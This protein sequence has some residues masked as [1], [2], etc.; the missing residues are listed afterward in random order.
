MWLDAVDPI[1][2]VASLSSAERLALPLI[3]AALSPL[4]LGCP[5]ALGA[6]RAIY[7]RDAEWMKHQPEHTRTGAG[8]G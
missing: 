3:A 4:V 6:H 7:V 8:Q 5:S 1:S 2:T